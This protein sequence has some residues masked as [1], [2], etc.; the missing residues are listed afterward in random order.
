LFSGKFEEN[1][2]FF[3]MSESDLQ[4]LYQS[5]LI[6]HSKSPLHYGKLEK[7]THFS[8]GYNPLCG[9]AI[10]IYLSVQQGTIEK[11]SFESASCAICK[12]S[13]SILL[14]AV[15]GSSG[16]SF[17]KLQNGFSQM[18]DG[19]TQDK[20]STLSSDISAFQGIQQFP[21][22]KNCALLPWSTL[23]KA[24]DSKIEDSASD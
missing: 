6:Q 23:K 19:D 21:S 20:S 9:D 10:S 5:I 18:L 12:A 17:S 1:E 15:E 3:P 13:A 7:F 14:E 8:E 24:L 4:E 11:A 16:E 22:R 2:I